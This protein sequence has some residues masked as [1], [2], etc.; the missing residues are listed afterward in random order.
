MTE[1]QAVEERLERERLARV[2]AERIAD[3]TIRDLYERQCE[4]QLLRSVAFAANEARSIEEA[5]RAAVESVCTYARW[6]A[7]H[8]FFVTEDERLVSSDIWHDE[9]GRFAAL[10]QQTA[11]TTFGRG[12][13]LPGHVLAQEIT[14]WIEDIGELHDFARVRTFDQFGLRAAVGV[15][16]LVG[17][18]L[19]AI[20]ELFDEQPRPFDGHFVDVMGQVGTML[21]RVI[22]RER[23]KRE[24][25]DANRRLTRALVD[26]QGAQEKIVQQERLRALGQMASGIAHD[27]NNAL[28]PIVGYAELLMEE[29]ELVRVP[30][31]QRYLRNILTSASDAASVVGR[32]REFYRKREDEDVL[33]PIDLR[34]I[35]QQVSDLTRPRWYNEALAS[36]IR[37]AVVTDL[38][39]IGLVMGHEAQLREAFM[40]LLLNAIDAMPSGGTIVLRTRTEGHRVLVEVCDSGVGMTEDVRRQC[41]EPFFTTK[42]NRGSGLGLGMVYGIVHRHDGTLNISSAPGRGTTMTLGFPVARAGAIAVATTSRKVLPPP[43]R[44]LVVDDKPSAR[45]LL[46]EMLEADGH[47]VETV[48]KGADGVTRLQETTFDLVLTDRSMPAMSGDELARIIKESDAPIPVIMITGFGVLMKSAGERPF[49]VDLVLPKPVTRLELREALAAVASPMAFTN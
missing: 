23:G 18:R 43:M 8:V 12:M 14:V 32:L 17:T 30:D 1:I 2:E 15:P 3:E 19:H 46:K 26:L 40:N 11:A 25:H 21:G 31:A 20:L 7:G 45:T 24:L 44:I 34:M 33:V 37:I 39:P 29:P 5:L 36:G 16:I 38:D 13:G 6:A 49:G 42:G 10:R 22:E 47:D 27:F 4:I 48:A 9:G 35:L 28:H 41:L